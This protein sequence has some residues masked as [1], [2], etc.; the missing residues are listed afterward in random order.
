MPDR[1]AR[2]RLIDRVRGLAARQLVRLP[3][4]AQRLLAGQR[5][6]VDG[7][8]LDSSLQLLLALRPANPGLIASGAP[9]SR[10]RLRREVLSV[11]GP[12]TPLEAVREITIPGAAGPLEARHFVPA[13]AESAPLLVYFHGGGYVVGDLDTHD[14]PCRLL[15]AHGGIHV[16]SVAYRLAPEHPFPAPLDDALAA[17]HWAAGAAAGLG[18]DRDHVAVGGDSAGAS[19][20]AVVCQQTAG[21]PRSPAAQL[22]IYPPTD[23]STPRESHRLFDEGYLLSMADRAAYYDAYLRGTG[24]DPDDPRVSPLRASHLGGLPP[25]LVVVAGFDILRDE[26][27]AYA[28]ALRGAGTRCEVVEA[29]SLAHGFINLTGCCPA[30]RQVTRDLAQRWRRFLSTT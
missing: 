4:A 12:R 8:E 16:V 18:A 2:P 1:L 30:A 27:R 17:F 7:R 11:R 6:V 3:E 28:Q 22:L 25:A 24:T 5:R 19:L 23:H 15:A 14:E 13:A 10:D 9:E 21:T 29:P 26:G 20:A